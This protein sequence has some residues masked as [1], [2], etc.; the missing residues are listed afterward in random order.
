MLQKGICALM[1]IN[2]SSPEPVSKSFS[3]SYIKYAKVKAVNLIKR[4]V[5]IEM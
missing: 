5:L 4:A 1:N 2:E 3:N